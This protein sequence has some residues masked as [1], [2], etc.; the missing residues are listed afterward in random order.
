M[1][2]K[3]GWY[4]T[5]DH[6]TASTKIFTHPDDQFDQYTFFVVQLTLIT[7]LATTFLDLLSVQ[8]SHHSLHWG[9]RTLKYMADMDKFVTCNNLYIMHISLEIQTPET[10]KDE[11]VLS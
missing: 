11:R 3:F 8:F 10:L 5:D 2:W 4:S 7:H 1:D 6:C 9:S